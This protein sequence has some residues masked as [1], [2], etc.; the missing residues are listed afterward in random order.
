MTGVV[1]NGAKRFWNDYR[2]EKSTIL[3]VKNEKKV[4]FF[5]NGTFHRAFEL[6]PG[7]IA[8]KRCALFESDLEKIHLQAKKIVLNRSGVD[9]FLI[10]R[11]VRIQNRRSHFDDPENSKT[12][13][14]QSK[15]SIP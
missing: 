1:E 5:M 6:K 9:F 7:P 12:S 14:K 13:S 10:F 2:S 15:G 8:V 4:R 3:K 11:V